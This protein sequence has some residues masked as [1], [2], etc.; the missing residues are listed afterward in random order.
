MI[1]VLQT[2]P[3]GTITH[4]YRFNDN[5]YFRKPLKSDGP[6]EYFGRGSGDEQNWRKTTLKAHAELFA[7]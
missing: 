5:F 1:Q 6:V 3:L 7:K 4:T 2:S